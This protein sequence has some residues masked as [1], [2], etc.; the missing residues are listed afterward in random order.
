M[1]RVLILGASGLVGSALRRRLPDAAAPA[2]RELDVTDRDALHATIARVRPAVV[3]N[4]T[5]LGVDGSERNPRLAAT[6][7]SEVPGAIAAEAAR[8]EAAFVHFSTNYVFD[9]ERTDRVP[10]SEI[11]EAQPLNA[12]GSTKLEG[13]R[14]ARRENDRTFVIRT[15]WVFGPGGQNFLSRVGG[16]LARGER[17]QAIVD[18]FA[19]VAYVE[20]LAS[21]V[22][23]IVESGEP[24]TYHVV[25][26][27]VCSYAEFAMQA[28]ALV[29]ADRGL[30]QLTG[31]SDHPRAARRPRW[32]PLQSIES[33]RLGLGPMR[34]WHDALA[35]FIAT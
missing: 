15:S 30:I 19:S 4:T 1:S 13:E 6:I 22:L 7:N 28:A 17:M 31:E 16:A 25:N 34:R 2:H 20:D 23:E 21:R 27:G 10:Y 33:P 12:Y 8:V 24:G 14:H 26:E 35:A 5:V 18:T 9:G 32:S 29:G 11:D 3:F